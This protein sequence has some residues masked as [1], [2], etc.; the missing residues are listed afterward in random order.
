MVPSTKKEIGNSH[1]FHNMSRLFLAWEKE[2]ENPRGLQLAPENR[3]METDY[4]LYFESLMFNL[5]STG[6]FQLHVNR[7]WGRSYINEIQKVFTSP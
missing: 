4:M 7:K 3:Y 2:G 5:Y 6:K 1:K